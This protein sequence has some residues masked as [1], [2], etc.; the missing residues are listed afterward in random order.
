MPLKAPSISFNFAIVSLLNY[1]TLLSCFDSF[2]LYLKRLIGKQGISSFSLMPS[3]ALAAEVKFVYWVYLLFALVAFSYFF[4]A[5]VE[6]C[7][8]VIF[9]V[10]VWVCFR[11][12]RER[13][14]PLRVLGAD[15]DV[16]MV[17]VGRRQW[18]IIELIYKYNK[19]AFQ[20]I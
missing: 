12:V 1:S 8:M 15:A 6:Y 4:V 9:L 3:S 10:G 16:V 17:G 2:L 20:E 5:A 14:M 7:G 11:W 19:K 18:R 13:L